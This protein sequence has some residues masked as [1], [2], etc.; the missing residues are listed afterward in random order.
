MAGV[1]V[2]GKAITFDHGVPYG[3]QFMSPKLH[4]QFNSHLM[5]QRKEYKMAHVFE[6]L[7]PHEHS[8]GGPGLWFYP[9]STLSK[10]V[11]WR[12]NPW[13]ILSTISHF[14]SVALSDKELNIS[15]NTKFKWK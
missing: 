4:F 10:G 12:V 15:E 11:I 14:H 8:H 9:G 6:P 7:T 13:R 5:T 2:L 1:A 3:C